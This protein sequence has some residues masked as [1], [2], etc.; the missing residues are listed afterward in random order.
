MLL[1]G[2]ADS[3]GSWA[4]NSGLAEARAQTVLRQLRSLGQSLPQIQVHSM[5]YAAPVACNDSDKGR[6]L[7]R[8]V[9]VWVSN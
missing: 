3:D 7:N 1:V 6:S 4:S 8:R 9:E 2:F 5:S